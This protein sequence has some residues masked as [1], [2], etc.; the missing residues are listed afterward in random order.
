MVTTSNNN[1]NDDDGNKTEE[2]GPNAA[3]QSLL[4][5]ATKLKQSMTAAERAV[6]RHPTKRKK[7][8]S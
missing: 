1:D 3:A 2:E 6:P 8:E 7:L 4:E 5:Q